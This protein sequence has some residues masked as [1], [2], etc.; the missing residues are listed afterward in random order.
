MSTITLLLVVFVAFACGVACGRR[1]ARKSIARHL[2]AR[3]LA[4]M[5]RSIDA[6]RN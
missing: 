2:V 6:C 1:G 3:E 4:S 5:I